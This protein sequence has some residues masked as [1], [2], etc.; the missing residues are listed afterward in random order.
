MR[1]ERDG[2]G[3]FVLSAAE[4]ASALRL[5]LDELRRRMR[6][7]RVASLVEAGE[8]EDAGRSRLTLRSGAR[9]WRAV[10]DKDGHVIEQRLSDSGA[11]R[12]LS[13][14]WRSAH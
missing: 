10:L 7:G 6:L 1:F 13:R 4:A 3:D 9:T 11:R 8:G 5:P 2:S 14:C 12:R